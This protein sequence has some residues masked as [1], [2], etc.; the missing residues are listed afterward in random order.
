LKDSSTAANG[1]KYEVDDNIFD[2]LLEDTIAW[3]PKQIAASPSRGT[4]N[5]G[6]LAPPHHDVPPLLITYHQLGPPVTEGLPV[7][8]E[9]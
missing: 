6:S 5:L 2:F 7:A 9:A 3:N 8:V 4:G 1:G